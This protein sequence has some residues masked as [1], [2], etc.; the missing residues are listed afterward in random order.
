MKNEVIVIRVDENWD[1]FVRRLTV[2]G[3]WEERNE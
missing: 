2:L 1:E 3:M